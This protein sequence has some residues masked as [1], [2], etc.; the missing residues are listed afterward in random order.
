[1]A[2]P[3]AEGALPTLAGGDDRLA[4]ANLLRLRGD[5]EA[6]RTILSDLL[7]RDPRDLGA[8]DL[9]ARL[10]EDAGDP[11]GAAH[12]RGLAHDVT[13]TKTKSAVRR[14]ARGT[15][16]IAGL[17][18]AGLVAL[19]V[20]SSLHP[21]RRTHRASFA[22]ASPELRSEAPE[23]LTG[24]AEALPP[25]TRNPDPKPDAN[26]IAATALEESALQRL[27]ATGPV[28]ARALVLE[29]DPRAAGLT[30]TFTLEPGENPRET[31]AALARRV[32][33]TFRTP[34]V[35]TL[36]ALV[37]KAPNAR[38]LVFLATATRER[39]AAVEPRTTDGPSLADALLTDEWTGDPT[40]ER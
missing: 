27:R 14:L 1:M 16:L 24:V 6:A 21:G 5:G 22:T 11:D 34:R 39:Y 28:G 19:V 13:P 26:T 18:T 8:L 12:W 35:L 20:A 23:L 37:A 32:F 2:R 33:A 36:R 25:S 15:L 9:M 31:A 40:V 30:L 29:H 3:G 4:R 17:A 38:E 7:A 10:H